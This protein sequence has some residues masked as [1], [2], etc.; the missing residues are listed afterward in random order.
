MVLGAPNPPLTVHHPMLGGGRAWAHVAVSISRALF[1]GHFR[2][3]STL[4]WVVLE[5]YNNES[6]PEEKDFG[7][8]WVPAWNARYGEHTEVAI[9]P[10]TAIGHLSRETRG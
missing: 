5:A 4:G 8:T 3:R 9:I 6:Y 2:A 10:G 1:D 7:V